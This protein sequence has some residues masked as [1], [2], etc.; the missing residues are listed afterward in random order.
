MVLWKSRRV[1]HQAGADSTAVVVDGR[2][3][4]VVTAITGI[5]SVPPEVAGLDLGEFRRVSGER[6]ILYLTSYVRRYQAN[7]VSNVS[8]DQAC[9]TRPWSRGLVSRLVSQ[10]LAA[11]RNSNVDLPCSDR[12]IENSHFVLN[13]YFPLLCHSVQ[14]NI[15]TRI[16]EWEK[17]RK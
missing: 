9:E 2:V 1:S 6:H 15:I 8:R 13:D 14:K 3:V 11:R 17:K 5:D 10:G 16:V 12:G 4:V 7:L